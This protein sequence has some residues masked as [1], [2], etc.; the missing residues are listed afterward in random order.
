MLLPDIPI[1]KY[2][3]RTIYQKNK[4]ESHFPMYPHITMQNVQYIIKPKRDLTFRYIYIQLYKTYNISG[5]ISERAYMPTSL[6]ARVC[7]ETKIGPGS[8]HLVKGQL[9]MANRTG[10]QLRR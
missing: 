2:T 6:V 10:R 7:R 9:Q 1:Y 5:S 4:R 3:K 8:I